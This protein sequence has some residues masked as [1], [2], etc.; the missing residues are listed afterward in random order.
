MA[1]VEVWAAMAGR[2]GGN[3]RVRATLVLVAGAV[4][5]LEAEGGRL[6]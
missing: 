1:E 5:I 4:G 3:T 2:G 6:V